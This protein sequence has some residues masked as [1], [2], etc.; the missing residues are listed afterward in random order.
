MSDS[1]DAKYQIVQERTLPVIASEILQI[2]R[3]VSAVAMDGA[4]QI[5]FKLQE[6]REKVPDGEWVKWLEEN[7]NYS[8]SQAYRF[9][10]ISNTYGNENSAFFNV[11]TSRNLSISKAFELLRLP[12][13]EAE[14][15][16]E[17]HDIESET[18][19]ELRQEITDLQKAK[20]KTEAELK[21]QKEEVSE[22]W[23]EYYKELEAS[24]Q[25]RAQLKEA[26]EQAAE[27]DAEAIEKIKAESAERE[28]EVQKKL[29]KA[30][31]DLKKAKDKLKESEDA[32]DEEV[33]KRLAEAAA[34][35]EEKH[36]DDIKKAKEDGAADAAASLGQMSEEVNRLEAQI[37]KLEAEKAKLSNNGIMKYGLLCEQLQETY[38]KIKAVMAAEEDE[39]NVEKMKIGLHKIWE[40]YKP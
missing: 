17:E 33:Q 27:F 21:E 9:I 8:K 3:T 37:E 16:V 18:V 15:F 23:D 13:A 40:A 5:G 14:K 39:T 1:I 36:A 20:E 19:K 10:Q 24:D 35:L 28:A 29:D 22:A 7:L 4:I 32:K 2:D 25:L 38:K 34:E 6:A 30:K 26:K 31:E 12:E 11:A